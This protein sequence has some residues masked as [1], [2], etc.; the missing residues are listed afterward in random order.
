[1]YNDLTHAD[2]ELPQNVADVNI[3]V[4]KFYNK[5]YE[6]LDIHVPIY[7]NFKRKYPSWYTKDIIKLIKDKAKA[8]KKFKTTN[9]VSLYRE[10]S[11]LILLTKQKIIDAYN[12]YLIEV[13]AKLI[14]EPNKLWNYINSK[15][16]T[17]RIPGTMI[18]TGD[19]CDKSQLIVNAFSDFFKNAFTQ[20]NNMETEKENGFDFQIDQNILTFISIEPFS[21]NEILEAGKK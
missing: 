14:N 15:N 5:F 7:E 18:Y 12:H 17:T 9:N 16:Q 6:L 3:A 13:Q 19:K 21:D 1:M 20:L 2:W 11:R 8:H 4:E 10:F